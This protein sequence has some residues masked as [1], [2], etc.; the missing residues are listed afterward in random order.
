MANQLNSI[1]YDTLGGAGYTGSLNDRLRSFYAYESGGSSNSSLMDLTYA[2][3]VSNGA[4][5]STLGDMWKELL[6]GAGYSGD[7][8]T[9]YYN[10]WEDGGTFT[11]VFTVPSPSFTIGEKT[12][13]GKNV[14]EYT[15][16][17][18]SPAIASIG[19][20]T[21]D[22]SN[23]FDVTFSAGTVSITVASAGDTAD[24]SGGPYTITI[25]C[26]S[27]AAQ[28]GDTDDMVFSITVEADTFDL[29]EADGIDDVITLVQSSAFLRGDTLK[30]GPGTYNSAAADKR[31][32]RS[33]AWNTALTYPSY[34]TD[35]RQG[36]D[37]TTGN[38][39]TIT[40]RDTNDKAIIR[41][42]VIDDSLS[43][44]DGFRFTDLAFY[45]PNDGSE[46]LNSYML[47]YASGGGHD[48]VV[49]S[50]SFTGGGF[51]F[52]TNE[53]LYSAIR[54]IGSNITIQD[55]E[56]DTVAHCFIS[57]NISGNGDGVSFIGNTIVDCW[58]E[59]AQVV[60][61]DDFKYNWNT[62][63]RKD[64]L[65]ITPELHSDLHQWYGPPTTATNVDYIGNRHIIG[66]VNE[67]PGAGQGSFQDNAATAARI[68]NYYSFGNIHSLD[69][70]RGD[71]FQQL[72][73]AYIR[74][75]TYINDLENFRS[76]TGIYVENKNGS[77]GDI[78]G[79]RI[80]DNVAN[81]VAVSQS[82]G[83][84]VQ[85]NNTS[86]DH[87]ND[88]T[89]TALFANPLGGA[90]LTIANLLSSLM[91]EASGA[92][93]VDD[94]ETII[95]AIAPSGRTAII[96]YDART[97]DFPWEEDGHTPSLTD[98]TGQST[99]APV[100]VEEQVT[101]VSTTGA[102]IYIT[103]GVSATFEI[104]ESDNSTV[105]ET[106]IGT[107]TANRRIIYANQYYEISDTTS[108]S[109]STQTDIV[110]YVGS[111]TDTW[112]HT[113]TAV[114]STAPAFASSNPADNAT[115]VSIGVNPTITFT[116]A[117]TLSFGTSKNLTLYDVT[118][119]TNEEVFSTATDVGTGP[120]TISLSGNTV[121]IE[122]TSD[123]TN[124]VEYAIKWDAGFVK[125]DSAN[126]VLANT[127]NTLVSFTTVAVATNYLTNGTFTVD[128][129]WTKGAPWS[130]GSGVA[131]CDGTATG[132]LY[133][134]S[135]TLTASSNY[136]FSVD[137]S[138]ISLDTGTGTLTMRI[139]DLDSG[140]FPNLVDTA[141]TIPATDGNLSVA[142]STPSGVTSV[143][144]VFQINQTGDT[145]DLDNAVIT[146]A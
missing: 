47:D 131:S 110:V 95:G 136:T 28:A 66:K 146:D 48:C 79:L 30:L 77:A 16:S 18:G 15:A 55:N 109:G 32:K 23:H 27:E 103:G 46:S 12:Q 63:Y 58:A 129:N 141:K 6:V 19:T 97:T 67:G 3:L 33:T 134:T 5:P 94:H 45:R 127:S 8:N 68:V 1:I 92:I 116:E 62:S 93:D 115:G 121:T 85:N 24:L 14:L 10:F 29:N 140:G 21:G 80:F 35:A 130:I 123:L 118:N 7:Y 137:V 124:S 122:P 65:D 73:D 72:D 74:N 4:T 82:T 53:E 2:Y 139:I 104:R 36:R 22:A 86:L 69:Q 144:A 100:S 40:S 41:H 111:E 75:N 38:L 11:T 56:F 90:D 101:G 108:G 78:T 133:Q 91:P 39:A 44:S 106:G 132:Q 49:D 50:C 26:Y 138:N 119:T 43:N 145:F 102:E 105:V 89:Y 114:D 84:D 25:P 31:I 112:S 117:N 17:G 60:G 99:G 76:A 83:E 126:D 107:G 13:A 143:E 98:L 70:A 51:T 61:G 20:K 34:K 96:D 42:L 81:A 142:F 120:G 135:V 113:T 57:P 9:M 52:A 37:L 87:T 71:S 88:A 125:D 59:G 128:S 54:L 64:E